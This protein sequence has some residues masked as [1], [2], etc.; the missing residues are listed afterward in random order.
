M[1]A[2]LQTTTKLASSA[3][4]AISF[5]TLA[6]TATSAE[7][8]SFAQVQRGKALVDAGDCVACHTQAGA[9]PFTGGRPIK[10]P[11]G[12]IYSPNITPDRETGI[13]AWSDEDF[14]RAMHEGIR[15]D[16]ARLYPAFPY[17]Y[18]TKMP[19][20]DVMAVRA[21]LN[22]LQP[23]PNP[24]PANKLFWPL[25]YRVFMRG[26]NAMFFTP[27]TFVADN[28]KDAE[29][30]R[31][32]YLVEGPG[33]CGACHTPKNLFG[34]GKSAHAL[35]GGA[36]QNWF[37]PNITSDQH[38]GI[39]SW[40]VDE[41]VE[42]LKT[43]RNA[44]SGAAGLM[45]EVVRDSTSKMSDS[46]LRAM[47]VY[48]KSESAKPGAPPLPDRSADSAGKAIYAD[49]CSGC[50]R[51]DGRPQCSGHPLA[52]LP[53]RLTQAQRLQKANHGGL[54]QPLPLPLPRKRPLR[55]PSNKSEPR[56]GFHKF[57]PR[58]TICRLIPLCCS[59]LCPSRN[60]V[61]RYN[62]SEPSTAAYRRL[63]SQANRRNYEPAL[64]TGPCNS[65]CPRSRA[66][67]RGCTAKWWS[68]M[69]QAVIGSTKA[70]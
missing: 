14:Y 13:G 32:A 5:G 37:A 36:I 34:S 58:A 64:G 51:S 24:R 45:S 48:L 33:H 3:V 12:V 61:L 43:G 21:Y 9:Q 57:L 68:S 30:N 28:G 29:W 67:Q 46:D 26:W 69:S 8:R 15:P 50:H 70:A 65:G 18:F 4:L 47:A 27:G 22:T 44:R 38:H 31:G 35:Q 17:P 2:T 23:T 52:G 66:A 10:T 54:H 40:T 53:G 19:R 20:E 42:Y 7:D 16:G 25:N 59:H 63:L 49:S 60:I 41:V 62:L 39:G 56:C 1:R 6:I 11:F 55:L